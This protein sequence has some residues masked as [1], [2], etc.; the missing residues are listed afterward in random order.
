[1]DFQRWYRRYD[2]LAFFVLTYAAT[3]G[4]VFALTGTLRFQGVHIP[5][6][7]ILM[8]FGAMLAGP[9]FAALALIALGDGQM[10]FRLLGK[11]MGRWKVGLQWYLAALLTAPAAALIVLLGLTALVSPVF[12]PGFAPV[13]LAVGLLAGFFEE[14]G[15]T[16]FALPRMRQRF[17]PLASALVIGLLWGL[18]HLA[19]DFSGSTPGQEGYWAAS[20][21]LFWLAPLVAY[22]VLMVWVYTH[23]RSLLLM[24]LMHAAYT[25]ALFALSPALDVELAL[26]YH[27]ALTIV[28][29]VMASAVVLLTGAQLTRQ[30]AKAAHAAVKVQ[31][32]AE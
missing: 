2:V 27:G 7:R 20:F 32:S 29:W 9:S 23:T 4:T 30:R 21:L 8:V 17:S 14:I 15:W 22:R 25:A 18:W 28:L 5:F 24:Q 6:E 31:L 3:W 13:G 1:L 26:V 10:G 12:A 19:A 11:H 16:G